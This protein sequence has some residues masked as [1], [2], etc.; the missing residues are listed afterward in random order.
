MI[1]W[2]Q[3]GQRLTFGYLDTAGPGGRADERKMGHG[4]GGAGLIIIIY[5]H[6][7]VHVYIYIHIHI[8]TMVIHKEATR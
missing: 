1:L 3:G 5:I 4:R 8:L 2:F 7:Y 6:T